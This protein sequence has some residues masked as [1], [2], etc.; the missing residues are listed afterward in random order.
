MADDKAEHFV[1]NVAQKAIIEHDGKILVC[2]G[3]GDNV[4]EFPGGRLHKGEAPME[5]IAREIREELGIEIY[6]IKPFR[7][8]PSFHY[9]SNMHQV[10]IAYTATSNTANVT[11]DASE[12]EEW[13]WISKEELFALP[14]FD[15]CTA[16]KR[17]LFE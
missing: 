12:V 9:K 2:R 4:W 13:K 10:F 6:D 7:I 11:A 17:A 8:E 15:D 1:G 3:I 16:V 14:M 5:A